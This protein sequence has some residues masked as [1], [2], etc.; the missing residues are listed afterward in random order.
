M[1]G[2]KE[3]NIFK[4]L[5]MMKTKTDTR[6]LM[7]MIYYTNLKSKAMINIVIKFI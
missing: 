3:T 2:Q 4:I 5:K 6:I 1:T 7:V